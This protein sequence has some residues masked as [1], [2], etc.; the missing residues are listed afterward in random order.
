MEQDNIFNYRVWNNRRLIYLP[1]GPIAILINA[2]TIFVA[3]LDLNMRTGMKIHPN[4]SA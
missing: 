1:L 3:E 2:A 4:A